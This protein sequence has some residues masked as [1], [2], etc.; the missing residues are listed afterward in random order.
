MQKVAE[1]LTMEVQEKM[2]ECLSSLA[3]AASSYKGLPA[4]SMLILDQFL[5]HVLSPS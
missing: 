1:L 4:D 2:D 3:L 5:H